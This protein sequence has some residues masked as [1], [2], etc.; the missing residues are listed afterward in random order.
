[1][2]KT[3]LSAFLGIRKRS[4][5][6]QETV[7]LTPVQ[8]IVTGVIAAAVLVIGLI[9]LVGIVVKNAIV[10]IDK[11]NQ[12]R[13]DGVSKREAIRSAAESRLRAAL[14]FPARAGRKPAWVGEWTPQ[15]GRFGAR[16]YE[17]IIAFQK[18]VKMPLD[19][20]PSLVMDPLNSFTATS[21][22]LGSAKVELGS[23]P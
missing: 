16:T 7:Q 13:E 6:E 22:G 1:M 18:R 17:A 4:G 20:K 21:E 23:K 3:V 2:V 10:L 15:D 11:V 14:A 9:L 5:H 12:L 19:G 8:I